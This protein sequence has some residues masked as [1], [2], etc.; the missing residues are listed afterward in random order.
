MTTCSLCPSGKFTLLARNSSMGVPMTSCVD[1]AVNFYSSGSNGALSA[2]WKTC[3]LESGLVSPSPEC[4]G[5]PKPVLA[6]DSCKKRFGEAYITG[7]PGATDSSF[8]MTPLPNFMIGS[9]A[10]VLALGLV[11]LYMGLGRFREVAFIREKRV[12][13]SQK[14][15][16]MRVV[17][18]IAAFDTTIV[19]KA[20]TKKFNETYKKI[21]G[22]GMDDV[23]SAPRALGSGNGPL[24]ILR[25]VF[26][27][28]LSVVVLNVVACVHF[29]GF[30]ASI[31]FKSLIMWKKMSGITM[32]HITLTYPAV[33]NGLMFS[34]LFILQS[35]SPLIARVIEL[36]LSPLGFF[37]DLMSMVNV[38]F[39][40]LGVTCSGS[41]GPLELLMNF[42]V[43]GFV[44]LVIESKYQL[45]RGITFKVATERFNK[46]IL[47]TDYL[48]SVFRRG[49]GVAVMFHGLFL[50]Q[51]AVIQMFGEIIN[52]QSFLQFTMS[53]IKMQT[54]VSGPDNLHAFSEECNT[55]P[56]FVN[57]DRFLG[58]LSTVVAMLAIVPSIYEVSKILC[59]CVEN[60]C[61]GGQTKKGDMDELLDEYS[62]LKK[63][64]GEQDSIESG[65]AS[66][67]SLTDQVSYY[68]ELITVI[69][70]RHYGR[71]YD[72]YLGG[73]NAFTER[74]GR[75]RDIIK[76]HDLYKKVLNET[77]YCKYDQ[78]TIE[79]LVNKGRY[80]VTRAQAMH[81]ILFENKKLRDKTRED[82]IK[83]RN[84]LAN[85]KTALGWLG[86]L[87]ALLSAFAPDVILFRLSASWAETMSS[88]VPRGAEQVRTDIQWLLCVVIPEGDTVPEGPQRD[89]FFSREPRLADLWDDSRDR[90][91]GRVRGDPSEDNYLL[92]L[93][94]VEKRILNEP[95]FAE[96]LR[97]VK[98]S[99]GSLLNC[100]TWSSLLVANARPLDTI[101][102]AA[103][104]EDK[105]AIAETKKLS[106]AGGRSNQ[107]AR[108][109]TSDSAVS[110][111]PLLPS[112]YN[113]CKAEAMAFG[114]NGDRGRLCK[115][116]FVPII[117][118]SCIGH[119]FTSVGRAA[120]W[121]VIRRYLIFFQTSLGFW[122]PASA[123][124]YR[125]KEEFESYIEEI[126]E[127]KKTASERNEK[128]SSFLL[129]MIA[130]RSILLQMVPHATA[131]S[132]YS[133]ATSSY[134]IY[135]SSHSLLGAGGEGGLQKVFPFFASDCWER[136]VNSEDGRHKGSRWL[137]YLN[138]ANIVFTESRAVLWF[139]QAFTVFISVVILYMPFNFT[140]IRGAVA[141]L[142]LFTA[143]SRRCGQ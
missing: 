130:P 100:S 33:L 45:F 1:C 101:E 46:L 79:G 142:L 22:Y 131:W 43:M 120:W 39:K 96:N 40:A 6:C 116:I 109:P 47:S 134:P 32:F 143:T 80:A 16:Y 113:L 36:L 77:G 53:F 107:A 63:A 52:F 21:Q 11:L 132:V 44:I 133:I 28:A 26:F 25:V 85:D 81:R 138:A 64:A 108:A 15:T 103:F 136:A 4:A 66:L 104:S 24:D 65:K 70:D 20:L 14:E 110:L 117:G 139:I 62:A 84:H 2:S 83:R 106:R 102:A 119:I 69:S 118:V 97:E 71:H 90:F 140:F 68:T 124:A 5:S 41:N 74:L 67:Q 29:A 34:V 82:D 54:F 8:C 72:T 95:G 18:A 42:A 126:T 112:F 56:G 57:F 125:V 37:F 49:G 51:C 61:C 93:N 75:Y 23:S 111:V 137:L 105:A 59:P 87:R 31:L 55:I 91:L 9:A 92:Y 128:Y 48:K 10:L 115:Y 58:S 27:L 35:F 135:V 99:R 7:L 17:K 141:V 86:S 89:D 88:S 12:I 98:T 123:V 19:E 38:N 60:G 78:R 3:Y 50:L 73:R 122:S 13:K 127:I 76:I 121:G 94:G 129:A 114:I 30:L